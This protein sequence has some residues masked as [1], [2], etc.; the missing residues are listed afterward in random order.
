MAQDSAQDLA[1]AHILVGAGAE[2]AAPVIRRIRP[3]DLVDALRAGWNDF[4]AMPTHAVF[5]CAIYPL[6]GIGIAG[7]TLGFAVIPL[8]FP[9]AAGFAL[10]GPLAAIALT[11]AAEKA[12]QFAAVGDCG[13]QRRQYLFQRVG[14]MRIVD[15]NQRRATPAAALHASRRCVDA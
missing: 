12:H 5:L 13:T 8:L 9:L 14:R 15:D 3:A 4:A 1:Q 6:V 7:L 10:L 2:P 11:T